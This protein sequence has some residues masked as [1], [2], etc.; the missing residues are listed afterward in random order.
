MHISQSIWTETLPTC[1]SRTINSINTIQ[2]LNFEL[3]C[4]LEQGSVLIRK[5][6]VNHLKHKY[7]APKKNTVAC[8]LIH[9]HTYAHTHTHTH[10][11]THT[12]MYWWH[13]LSNPNV[14]YKILY[15]VTCTQVV[16]FP[17]KRIHACIYTMYISIALLL[18]SLSSTGAS[19]TI[20]VVIQW[21]T[22]S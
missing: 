14:N 17:N 11:H 9:T 20:I 3:F 1:T 2:N 22:G 5:E 19:R 10:A 15:N 21:L 4:K 16:Q 12:T 8:T 6:E 18:Y 13:K 7:T